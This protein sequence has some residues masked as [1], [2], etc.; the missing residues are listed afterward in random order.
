[1][2]L[3]STLL[4]F[5]L[6]A[7]A[8]AGCCCHRHYHCR[9]IR[10]QPRCDGPLAGPA[11]MVPPPAPTTPPIPGMN[12]VISAPAPDPPPRGPATPF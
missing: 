12:P 2:S 11:V 10:P 4:A 1:M 7:L 9:V 5:A 8:S 6:T 3:R